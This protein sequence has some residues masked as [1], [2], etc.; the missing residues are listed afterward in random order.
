MSLQNMIREMVQSEIAKAVK[1]A[2]SAAIGT[3]RYPTDTDKAGRSI[4]D[5]SFG[6]P[7]KQSNDWRKV[8]S[9]TADEPTENGDNP[10]QPPRR[11]K[12]GRGRAK[13]AY[14][15]MPRKQG[16]R[17]PDLPGNP[18]TVLDALRNADGPLTNLELEELTGMSNKPVQSA[19]HLL[20]TIRVI[21][22]VP[23]RRS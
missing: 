14:A 1:D 13:V 21:K 11:R 2:V 16:Q 8:R 17:W 22:S 5:P 20:R 6:V 12:R 19:V 10:Q 4:D 7:A 15:L 9:F 3:A 18:G 23:I